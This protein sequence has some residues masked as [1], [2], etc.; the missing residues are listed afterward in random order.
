MFSR[1]DEKLIMRLFK[2]YDRYSNEKRT[3]KL[4]IAC[5]KFL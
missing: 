4:M 5:D 2:E 3:A 1:C